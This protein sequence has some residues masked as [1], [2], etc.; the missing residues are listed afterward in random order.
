MRICA[1]FLKKV[2]DFLF[3]LWYNGDFGRLTHKATVSRPSVSIK[4]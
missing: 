2:L 3:G 1:R 4:K